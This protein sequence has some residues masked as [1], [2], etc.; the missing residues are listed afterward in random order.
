MAPAFYP[1]ESA[2]D[3]VVVG[4]VGGRLI[5]LGTYPY[6]AHEDVGA[7]GTICRNGRYEWSTAEPILYID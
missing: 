6:F 1:L 2:K 5:P 3:L 7:A 4:S